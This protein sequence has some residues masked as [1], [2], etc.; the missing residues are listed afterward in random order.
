MRCPTPQVTPARGRALV[1][2]LSVL[3]ELCWGGNRFKPALSPLVFHNCL[4]F[5]LTPDMDA[6][7]RKADGRDGESQTG[8]AKKSTR[9]RV[10]L[11]CEECRVR[12]RR[13]DGST[14]SCAGCL[15]RMTVCVYASDIQT[16]AWR[17]RS[18]DCSSLP[19][20]SV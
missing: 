4:R 6:I 7:K 10:T 17:D 15:K 11:A 18:V 1:G 9:H 20:E 14:P 12:K 5:L 19:T 3:S 2:N 13:C 16:E 8:G